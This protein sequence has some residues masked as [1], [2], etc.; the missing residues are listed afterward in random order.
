MSH[1]TRAVVAIGIAIAIL[2]LAI[3]LSYRNR[4][5]TGSCPTLGDLARLEGFSSVVTLL[6]M[7]GEDVTYFATLSATYFEIA[8]SCSEDEFLDWAQSQG[9][10]PD[11]L[12]SCRG[13]TAFVENLGDQSVLHKV[14]D[15]YCLQTISFTSE[16]K[17]Q[18]AR[19]IVYDRNAKRVNFQVTLDRL[20][21]QL[22]NVKC[23]APIPKTDHAEQQRE[24]I[25][26]P[27]SATH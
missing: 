20:R 13:K 25:A 1:T 3:G 7:H 14:D 10:R 11:D 24:T 22:V 12:Q 26:P 23:S 4:M 27:E 6:P 8:F 9:W 21:G 15:A 17:Q 16:G 19:E 18:L 2:V 5:L